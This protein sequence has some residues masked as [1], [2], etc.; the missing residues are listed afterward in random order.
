MIEGLNR[1]LVAV[2]DL[3][4]QPDSA[5]ILV[6]GSGGT[7]YYAV[8]SWEIFEGTINF[9]LGEK[10]VFACKVDGTWSIVQRE[11]AELV[12]EEEV[13]RAS[14]DDHKA[15]EALHKELHPEEA[16]VGGRDPGHYL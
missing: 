9:Y 12:R 4:E 3:S 10:I 11:V 8:D 1:T 15:L 6:A 14:R 7:R 13:L 16:P 5:Y 2:K